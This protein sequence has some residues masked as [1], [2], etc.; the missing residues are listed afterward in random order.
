[1]LVSHIAEKIEINPEIVGGQP[2]ITGTRF[3]V[4]QI[5]VWH[6]YMGMSVDEIAHNYELEPSAIHAALAYYF[7]NRA[8][9]QKSISEESQLVE[10]LKKQFPSKL[11]RA[12]HA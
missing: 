3:T 8:E 10:Q 6:E 4:K 1:M 12:A 7:D 5:V 9:I 11:Q 2:R